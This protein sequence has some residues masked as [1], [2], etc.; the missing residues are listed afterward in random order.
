[1]KTTKILSVFL[2]VITLAI[3]LSSCGSETL[4]GK[5]YSD[6]GD[7][8]YYEFNGKD[9]TIHTIVPMTTQYQIKGDRLILSAS[10]VAG[11]GGGIEFSLS[12]D[13]KSFT[14]E[15]GIAGFN[16]KITYTKK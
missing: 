14:Q 15:S 9:V 13:R 2:L 10:G 8:S 1:M 11:V 12:K 4:S 6:A 7:G 5:Y 16:V 3:I